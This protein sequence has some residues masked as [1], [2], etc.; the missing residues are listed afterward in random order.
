MKYL[1][2][3]FFLFP[4]LVLAQLN[5]SDTLKF[6]T[7]LNLNGNWQKGNV[8][9]LAFRSKLEFTFSSSPNFVF[10]T[11]NAYLYQEFFGNKADED[12]FSRNFIYFYPQNKIY[13]F[14]VS[15]ISQNF[16]RK[17]DFRYFVGA[18]ATLQLIHTK[19]H[20]LKTALSTVYEESNFSIDIFNESQYDGQKQINT[21]RGTAWIF[22]KH[23]FF[24]NKLNFYYESYIQPSFEDTKNFRWQLETGLETPI[25]KGLNFSTTFIYTYEKIVALGL[26][27]YDHSL[28]F[29]FSYQFKK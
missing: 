9:V 4:S 5:E 17:I 8:E 28:L 18:G 20:I 19:S 10:K 13:P 2:V 14:A 6:Q 7:K 22:G 11:Q 26:K 23:H 15:F 16:R 29:G 24:E 1:L 27:P 3:L 12:L 25:W 21:W